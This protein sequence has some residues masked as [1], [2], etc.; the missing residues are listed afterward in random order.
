M[1]TNKELK[2]MNSFELVN[3]LINDI[4]LTEKFDELNLWKSLDWE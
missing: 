1:M 4:S 2:Q 3:S